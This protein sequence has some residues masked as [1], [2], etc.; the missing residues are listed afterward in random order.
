[1]DE[2][3]QDIEKLKEETNAAWQLLIGSLEEE[4]DGLKKGGGSKI[5]RN[6]AED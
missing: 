2:Q 5:R 6:R 3:N 4:Y 1:M